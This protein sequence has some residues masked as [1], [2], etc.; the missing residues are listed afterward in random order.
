MPSL[1][2][3]YEQLSALHDQMADAAFLLDWDKVG[4]IEQKSSEITLAL[5][6]F[7]S[8]IASQDERHRTATLIRHILEKQDV[9]REEIAVWKADVAPLLAVLNRSQPS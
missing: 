5:Q 2:T 8:K 6:K 9:V 1:L 3:L 7:E 4:L